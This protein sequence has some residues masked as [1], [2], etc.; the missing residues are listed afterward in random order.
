MKLF[1]IFKQI[2]KEDMYVDQ[3]G[4]LVDKGDGKDISD[5]NSTTIT[6]L[7][8]QDGPYNNVYI[9]NSSI[10]TIQPN[11]EVNG[12]LILTDCKKL[13]AIGSNLKVGGVL[14]ITGCIAL[15]PE[16]LANSRMQ[17]GGDL[18]IADM[19]I[20]N[21][22]IEHLESKGIKDYYT[23]DVQKYIK[24]IMKKSFKCIVNGDI[25]LD[26]ETV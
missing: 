15:S 11:V 12:D 9:P 7:K 22:F 17:I 24:N 23:P 20:G 14:D 3:S 13:F 19:S 4:K 8:S 1:N 25:F 10:K 5:A 21:L 2:L 16:N 18:I 26:R 6:T